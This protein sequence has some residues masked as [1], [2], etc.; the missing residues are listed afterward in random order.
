MIDP[1][2]EY[3]S[4]SGFHRRR[5]VQVSLE[6]SLGAIAAVGLSNCQRRIG[7]PVGSPVGSPGGASSGNSPSPQGATAAQKALSIYTWADYS[8]PN[9]YD[10]FAEATQITITADTYDSNESMLSKL[11][12]GGGNAYSLI[13][14]TDYMVTQMIDLGLLHPLDKSKLTGL[15]NLT[16]RW[17]NPPYDPDNTYSLPLSWGTTGFIY[18]K[19]L[20]GK[21]LADWQDIWA[22]REQLKGKMVLLDDVR[23]TLG[24]ALKSLGYSLNSIKEDE[25]IE[26]TQ[27]IG[28]IKPY[29]STFQSFGWEEQLVAGD[30]LLAM[31]YSG[32]GNK[33]ALENPDLDYVI[34]ASGASLWTDTMVIP[35]TAP[36]RDA[37]YAWMNFLLE[38]KNLVLMLEKLKFAPPNDAAIALLSPELRV[39]AD[40]FPP[41]MV[42]D[43]CEAIA[44]IGDAVDLYD[45]AWNNLKSS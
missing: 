7:S 36:N 11:Q 13:Y 39:N 25:I 19:K 44:D 43:K 21:P 42:L 41:P 17:Q 22:I 24:A 34:P 15:T 33:L 5:F 27:V 28:Q 45:Q 4:M 40:L 23:E 3:M 30:L 35:K 31:T 18:N 26:A 20:I 37:A 32:T 6:A 2:S 16:P 14:P 29:L 12:A 9:I 10:R 38:P 1:A 8:D